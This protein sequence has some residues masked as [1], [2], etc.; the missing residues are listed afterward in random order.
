MFIVSVMY[1]SGFPFD[2][3]YY[4]KTHADLVNDR[5]K[6]LGLRNL[7]VLLGQPGPDGTAPTYQVVANLTFDSRAAFEGAAS[8]HA[9]EIFADI[10]NFTSATPIVQLSE[11]A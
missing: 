8:Q 4:G 7:Q 9:S 1:P 5:W 11:A 3:G 6:P 2:I 10:P